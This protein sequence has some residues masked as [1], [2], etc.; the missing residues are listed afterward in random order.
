[1]TGQSIRDRYRRRAIRELQKHSP[2]GL[3][4]LLDVMTGAA[5]HCSDTTKEALIVMLRDYVMD[6]D[7]LYEV[8]IG[9]R[10]RAL[11]D[12]DWTTR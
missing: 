6:Q 7:D 5:D 11:I 12:G 1:M 9:E 10:V 8:P 4:V 3:E 2:E